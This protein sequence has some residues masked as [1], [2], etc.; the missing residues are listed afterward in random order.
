MVVR[1]AMVFRGGGRAPRY[2][3]APRE[4]EEGEV[5]LA[6]GRERKRA[7]GVA[8]VGCRG[9]LG[10]SVVQEGDPCELSPF[11]PHPLRSSQDDVRSSR[12][13]FLVSCSA[14]GLA[15]GRKK[16]PRCTTICCCCTLP[17]S[18][19]FRQHNARLETHPAGSQ[20]Q[21]QLRLEVGLASPSN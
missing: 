21:R 20:G 11:S 1:N 6:R 16:V 15:L 4:G 5:L 13:I 18:S 7:A 10:G 2:C 12:L 17:C 3:R 8:A 19:P 9:R 14:V